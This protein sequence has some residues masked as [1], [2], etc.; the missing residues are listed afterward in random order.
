MKPDR[1]LILHDVAY[2]TLRADLVD[3]EYEVNSL[4]RVLVELGYQVSQMAFD[5]HES[6]MMAA[7][8]RGWQPVLVFNL[9]E[10]VAGS[11]QLAHLACSFLQLLGIPFT[12]A[13]AWSMQTTVNKL[14]T[15]RMLVGS[16]L[17]TPAWLEA[18]GSGSWNPGSRY[19][20]KPV[21]EDGSVAIE[22]GSLVSCLDA[23]RLRA[24]IEAHSAKTGLLCFAEQFID[25]REFNVS[26]LGQEGEAHVLPLAEME[27]LGFAENGLAPMMNFDAKWTEGSYEY[28]HIQ[29]T[30]LPQPGDGPLRD[31]LVRIAKACWTLFGL[32]GYARI[33]FRVD[34]SGQPMVIEINTNP[35]LEPDNGIVAAA[36]QTGID[37]ATLLI[38]I[39]AE[40]GVILHKQSEHESH[41]PIHAL[42]DDW[43]RQLASRLASP[44]DLTAF[45]SQHGESNVSD[46][47]TAGVNNTASVTGSDFCTEIADV[48][49][50]YPMAV[51]PYYASLAQ[52][53]NPSCP[54]RRQFVPDKSELVYAQNEVDDPLE[55]E[56]HS[57]V[58][59]LIHRYPDRVLLQVSLECAVYCRHCSRKRKVGR[60]LQSITMA[61]I[62]EGL[63]YIRE[64][65]EVRDVLLSGG[66]PLMLQDTVL[67]R[68][69]KQLRSIPHV[70][71]IRIG[72]R[73][74]VVLPQRITPEL[75]EILKAAKPLWL[76]TQFN[77]PQEFT[78]DSE[79]ALSRLADAG[80]P[81]GN[82]TVLLKGINDSPEVMRSLLH[83]L[84]K[85]RV[86]PYYLYHCDYVRGV[87]HFRTTIRQGIQLMRQIQGH[88]SGFAVPGY[89]IDLP[90]GGGKVALH[91]SHELNDPMNSRI[92]V[93]NFECNQYVLDLDE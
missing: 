23:A 6:E 18:D 72:T 34:G 53:N 58:P 81:L 22:R 38:R 74:P 43:R 85:N 76:N 66:D 60:S 77:H 9:V 41:S 40:A 61:T 2:E 25:G 16:G 49:A 50:V 59:G 19:L 70:E 1:V 44:D 21:F 45:S 69:L 10:T 73:M 5:P 30:F 26:L 63:D 36:S 54:I 8:I 11:G 42:S 89:I 51:T 67:A 84:V 33:D 27:F 3:N 79:S 47:N 52:L 48:V 24:L 4:A 15:K 91:Q 35:C 46:Q 78:L 82:Q 80:I 57:P 90:Q 32:R 86:R 88:T 68:I 29:R 12:G 20:I 14:A 56:R 28:E 55:E 17:P 92:V 65:P 83:Q 87:G 93:E 13:D 39:A 75:I 31:E 37:F 64:H 62:D 71:V 7:R